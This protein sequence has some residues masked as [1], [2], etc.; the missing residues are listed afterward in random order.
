MSHQVAE[1]KVES[2]LS[3]VTTALRLSYGRCRMSPRMKAKTT[4]YI[5]LPNATWI[6]RTSY[7][8]CRCVCVCNIMMLSP[9]KLLENLS[10]LHSLT[11]RITE[12]LVQLPVT[13]CFCTINSYIQTR[14]IPL[15]MIAAS[16]R[17]Y[18][19]P[20]V[21]ILDATLSPTFNFNVVF[22]RHGGAMFFVNCISL[23]NTATG[24]K[25]NYS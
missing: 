1:Y 19:F 24:H 23:V 8:R 20:S 10:K 12:K 7:D 15:G 3:Y 17:D 14:I 5:L 22:P 21:Y 4:R 25:P 16:F 18:C 9:V 2:Q 6:V 13:T 11:S